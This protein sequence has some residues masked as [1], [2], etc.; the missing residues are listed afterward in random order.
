MYSTVPKN[1]VLYNM[2]LLLL[3]IPLNQP[4][5]LGCLDKYLVGGGG[6]GGRWHCNYSF[7]LQ[8]SMKS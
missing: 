3:Y 5:I 2:L 6:C 4:L 8:R 7:K 1:T